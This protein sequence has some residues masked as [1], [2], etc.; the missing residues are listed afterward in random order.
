MDSAPYTRSELDRISDDEFPKRG[1][2]CNKCQTHIPLFAEQS[3]DEERRIRKLESKVQQMVEL[4]KITGC[5]IRW[6]K[7][8]ALHPDG[9]QPHRRESGPPCPQCG[10]PLRTPMAKQCVNCGADWH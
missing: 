1:N 2:F 10:E 8:W 5:T 9:P 6:A 4:R 7:I 3:A